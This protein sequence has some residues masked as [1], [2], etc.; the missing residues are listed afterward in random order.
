[1]EQ[2]NT[3]FEAGDPGMEASWVTL[4]N[5]EAENVYLPISNRL[6]W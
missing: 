3:G 2:L 5:W 4:S 6:A 1:M